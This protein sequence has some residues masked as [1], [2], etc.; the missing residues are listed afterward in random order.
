MD[1]MWLKYS[2]SNDKNE[3][4]I[5]LKEEEEERLL[6]QC[7]L[8]N[9][10]EEN[11]TTL[12]SVTTQDQEF[13][14]CSRVGDSFLKNSTMCTAD[15]VFFQGQILPL[16]DID[17]RGGLTV[18][19]EA[20]LTEYPSQDIR[21]GSMKHG[22][23]SIGIT[24]SSINSSITKSL[25]SS[26]NEPQIRNPFHSQPSPTPQIRFSKITNINSW[27]RKST[28]WSLFRVGLVT[29][30]EIALQDLKIRR[31]KNSNN[32]KN[33]N[34]DNRMRSLQR[35][36]AFLGSCKCSVEIVPSKVVTINKGNTNCKRAGQSDAQ[37]ILCL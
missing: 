32:S 8:P 37:N 33:N 19:N 1:K 34:I 21:T 5:L 4:L 18:S 25:C 12:A 14:F 2:N 31:N 11:Q 13:D 20:S 36:K 15:E 26:S 29:I 17:V 27:N 16:S 23:H 7:D 10:N 9:N 3:E 28:M 6:S 24:N 35:K 22:D 30:P